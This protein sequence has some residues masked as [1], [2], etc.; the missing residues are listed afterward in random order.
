MLKD[1]RVLP[2]QMHD[3]FVIGANG[4]LGSNCVKYLERDGKKVFKS[5]ARLENSLDMKSQIAESGARRVIC[6]AG[7]KGD[8]IIDACE[9]N[10][11]ETRKINYD[12]ILELIEAC[13]GIHLTIMGSGYIYTGSKGVYTEEDEGDLTSLIY[14]KYKILLEKKVSSS[15]LYLRIMYPSSFDGHPRCFYKK[16]LA[17]K[18]NLH[19]SRVSITSIPHLFPKLD[20]MI[21]CGYSGIYNFVIDGTISLRDLV[22]DDSPT[23]GTPYGNYELSAEKLKTRFKVIKNTELLGILQCGSLLQ[24]ELG[25]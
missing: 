11:E 3:Y 14:C 1:K 9:K 8:S 10:Q 23:T 20:H 12:S 6:C 22:G 25:S 13:R 7:F 19:D 15:V 21:S 17:R 5:S 24:E 18:G 16:T 2:D 4:F